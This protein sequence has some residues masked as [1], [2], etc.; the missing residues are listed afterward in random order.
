[1]RIAARYHV[2]VADLRRWNRIGGARLVA[3]VRLSVEPPASR[4]AGRGRAEISAAHRVRHRVR[5]GETLAAIAGRYGVTVRD[6]ARWNGVGSG[7]ALQAGQTIE[8]YVSR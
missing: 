8:L 4:S 3:G 6:I 1:A 2:G 5:R 7:H